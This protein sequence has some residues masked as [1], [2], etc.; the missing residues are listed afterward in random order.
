MKDGKALK[1]NEQ[2]SR[3]VFNRNLWVQESSTKWH[4]ISEYLG[5]ILAMKIGMGRWKSQ[6]D[7]SDR[8]QKCACGVNVV[9]IYRLPRY[10][11]MPENEGFIALAPFSQF[12]GQTSPWSS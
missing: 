6:A 7:V 2:S 9:I 10:S 1:E 3:Y 11:A 8:I 4:K 12:A 5:Y